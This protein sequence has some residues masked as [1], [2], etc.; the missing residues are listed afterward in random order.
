M[1]REKDPRKNLKLPP[2]LYEEIKRVA[3]ASR[4]YQS[5]P[6][7]IRE[8]IRVR[9]LELREGKARSGDPPLVLTNGSREG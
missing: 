6:D 3:V 5:V 7:F 8:A 2:D 4:Q 9:L 1:A